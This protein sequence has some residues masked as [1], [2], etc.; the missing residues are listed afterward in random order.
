MA[1]GT[2][3]IH[4]CTI[5]VTWVFFFTCMNADDGFLFVVDGDG[6]FELGL[7]MFEMN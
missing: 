4:I 3:A 7:E 5:L 6:R 1:Y 2:I